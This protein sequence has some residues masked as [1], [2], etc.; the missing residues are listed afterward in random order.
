MNE[1]FNQMA[2]ETLRFSAKNEN[3]MVQL[4]ATITQASK[5][6]HVT[7]FGVFVIQNPQNDTHLAALRL[8]AEEKVLSAFAYF[9]LLS[10]TYETIRE[11]CITCICILR[12]ETIS[13]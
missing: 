6:I 7:S 9:R 8:R 2:L 1:L 3:K 13:E 5:I 12:R 4:A 11:D 10:G